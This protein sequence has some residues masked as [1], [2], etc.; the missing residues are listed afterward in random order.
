MTFLGERLSAQKLDR[1]PIAVLRFLPAEFAAAI[2]S[3]EL[4]G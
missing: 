3:A 2:L 1:V 4:I